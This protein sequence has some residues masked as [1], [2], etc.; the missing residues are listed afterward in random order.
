MPKA[1]FRLPPG[2]LEIIDSRKGQLGC[3]SRSDV[4]RKIILFGFPVFKFKAGEQSRTTIAELQRALE[5]DYDEDRTEAL[6]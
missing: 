5:I 6:I 2:I 4:L 3:K 1:N